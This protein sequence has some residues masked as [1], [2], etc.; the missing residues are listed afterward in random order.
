MCTGASV[1]AVSDATKEHLRF[2]CRPVS[3]A[4]A[5][6]AGASAKGSE[7]SMAEGEKLKSRTWSG[8]GLA[9][10]ELRRS[11]IGYRSVADPDAAGI[12]RAITQSK[13]RAT[14]L[15]EECGTALTIY[16]SRTAWQR[17]TQYAQPIAVRSHAALRN[18]PLSVSNFV[19]IRT[20]LID[21][22]TGDKAMRLTLSPLFVALR[23]QRYRN[24]SIRADRV[25]VGTP[26]PGAPRGAGCVRNSMLVQP[27]IGLCEATGTMQIVT[28]GPIDDIPLTLCPPVAA[29]GILDTQ[30]DLDANPN[31]YTEVVVRTHHTRLLQAHGVSAQMQRHRRGRAERLTTLRQRRLIEQVA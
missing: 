22:T 7:G 19:P 2:E 25:A 24:E 1:R 23:S 13:I 6:G 10:A 16:L 9:Q 11:E 21:A 3:S 14:T 5:L 4:C 12:S 20:Q 26:V 27:T 18:I 28:T 31:R 30:T 29:E 17:D 15:P 8:R